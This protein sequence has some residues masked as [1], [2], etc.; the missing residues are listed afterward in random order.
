MSRFNVKN[1]VGLG[2]NADPTRPELSQQPRTL[3]FGF[4]GL[5]LLFLLALLPT[6]VRGGA[7][8]DLVLYRQW[9]ETGLDAG[10]WH[11]IQEPWVYPIVALVP[12]AAAAL[13]GPALYQL[14]WFL[15]TMLLNAM[16]VIV[17]TEFGRKKSGY[18]AAWWWLL[19][20]FI[21]S[22]VGLLRLEGIVAPIVIIALVMLRRRPIVASALLA[23]ATWIKVWP[24][25]VVL[26]IVGGARRRGIVV[27]TF[28]GVSLAIAA[29]VFALGGAANLLSFA[30]TQTGR[31]LQLEAPVSTPWVWMAALDR[32][33]S[34]IFQNVE[35]ATREVVGAGSAQAAALM[36]PLLAASV[37]LIFV[38]I[39]LA[40]RRNS[41]SE[42]LVLHGALTLAVALIVFNKVGS[43]Q[44]MLWIVPIVVVG[45][46]SDLQRW[47]T[48]AS[49]VLTISVLTTL[50]FPIFYMPL[51]AGNIAAVMLL[52]SRNVLLVVL[53]AWSMVRLVQ[54]TRV[55]V[56]ATQPHAV[57][58]G[59]RVVAPDAAVAL[60]QSAAASAPPV[61]EGK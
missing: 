8:G 52:T 36:T 14:H 59:A 29:V 23:V 56:G 31:G 11:G 1:F 51:A 54:L 46:A 44:Y 41:D 38:L 58:R 26:A 28:L 43:P 53:F 37:V 34:Y 20:S 19:V 48:P 42:Y 12:I 10:I 13:G 27:A 50:I 6:I 25:A 21:L 57:R 40:R 22:P 17:L 3:L 2:G 7:L 5:H 18:P 45:L 30:G 55:P 35:L 61:S 4:L 33:G 32:P 16:A 39:M 9:A 24:I 60:S 47:R 49:L 15:I